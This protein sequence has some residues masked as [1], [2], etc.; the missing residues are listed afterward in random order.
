MTELD[1]EPVDPPSVP[2]WARALELAG[3]AALVVHCLAGR[4]ST[5]PE[6][7]FFALLA[8]GIVWL[9][10]LGAL[11]PAPQ[12]DAPRNAHLLLA[13]FTGLGLL[14]MAIYALTEQVH[15]VPRVVAI[16]AAIYV[17]YAYLQ[18]FLA[19]RYLVVRLQSWLGWSPLAVAA[20]VAAVFSLLHLPWP[21]LIP[22]TILAGFVWSYAYL[23]GGRVWP[24]A[25]SHALLAVGLFMLVLDHAPFAKAF[26][27]WPFGG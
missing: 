20:V 7:A 1:A 5:F 4:R 14:A 23:K 26:G 13:G 21:K 22:P 17:P 3:A 16:T 6:M 8:L 10:R 15:P 27:E 24:I 2:R 11:P 12:P 9:A 25:T 19:Q 18:Q